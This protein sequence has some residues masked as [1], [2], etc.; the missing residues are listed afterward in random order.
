MPHFT[1]LKWSNTIQL[2]YS[3]LYILPIICQYFKLWTIFTSKI[4]S[5]QNGFMFSGSVRD[6]R[7]LFTICSYF[8]HKLYILHSCFIYISSDTKT[9][10]VHSLFIIYTN[11]IHILFKIYSQKTQTTVLFPMRFSATQTYIYT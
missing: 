11:F 7:S 6:Y 10:F 5:T 2:S 1:V 4:N 9:T 3:M 8:I